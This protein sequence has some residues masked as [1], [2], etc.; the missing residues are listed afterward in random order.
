MKELGTALS[1][2]GHMKIA[3]TRKVPS[4][5]T[6]SMPSLPSSSPVK[7]PSP[8]SLVK[9]NSKCD[10]IDLSQEEEPIHPIRPLQPISNV[11][12]S[13]EP[14]D[15]ER[16]KKLVKLSHPEKPSR[17]VPS[18]PMPSQLLNAA[19]QHLP[20]PELPKPQLPR[21]SSKAAPSQQHPKPELPNTPVRRSHI[22]L[23]PVASKIVPKAPK[24]ISKPDLLK[25]PSKPEPSQRQPKLEPPK[26]VLCP[27]CS[28]SFT[29]E[30]IDGHL[31][32][33]LTHQML[34]DES[35]RM[36]LDV[37][38]EPILYTTVNTTRFISFRWWPTEECG[39]QY[40]SGTF[41]GRRRDG[42]AGMSVSVSQ[43]LHRPM[44]RTCRL[45]PPTPIYNDC[46][47]FELPL[48]STAGGR[49]GEIGFHSE[50]VS[51]QLEH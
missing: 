41:P 51:S 20:K 2:V 15:G 45:L 42:Q 49:Q 36:D 44:G 14:Q 33:C 19:R 28:Q 27:V 32:D 34:S 37:V 48:G 40:L 18:K 29:V 23:Q 50:T 24:K 12:Q 13:K 39:V 16:P 31:N 47:C 8:S 30:V 5:F 43:P 11:S 25:P 1:K 21:T 22:S 7:H 4:G 35:K 26:M 38:E 17:D 46:Y 10:R 3:A 9:T 6:L